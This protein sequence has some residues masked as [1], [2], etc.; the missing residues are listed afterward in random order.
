MKKDDVDGT[1]V[2]SHKRMIICLEFV[3]NKKVVH[4]MRDYKLP[5]AMA[6]RSYRLYYNVKQMKELV[7]SSV[8]I[9]TLLFPKSRP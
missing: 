3:T 4:E 7:F 9:P 8:L 5:M 1:N 6:W 2:I